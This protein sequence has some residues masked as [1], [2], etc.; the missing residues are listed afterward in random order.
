L[1]RIGNQLQN[2]PAQLPPDHP[3][4]VLCLAELGLADYAIGDKAG[5][6]ILWD[7]ALER[8]PRA[9]PVQGPEVRR[10]RATIADPEAALHPAQGVRD[11]VA[12]K[13]S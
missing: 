6:K 1:T 4:M 7:D 11:A 13:K 9:Y 5:A 8:M 3:F 10:I 12:V 2:Q